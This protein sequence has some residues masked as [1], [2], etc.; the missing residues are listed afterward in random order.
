MAQPQAAPADDLVIPLDTTGVSD[1]TYLN[2]ANVPPAGRFGVRFHNTTS[3]RTF[4]VKMPFVFDTNEF[5]SAFAR[6]RFDR[7]GLTLADIVCG[8]LFPGS[9]ANTNG[10]CVRGST[11]SAVEGTA[12]F[13]IDALDRVEELRVF[14]EALDAADSPPATN[15]DCL[16]APVPAPCLVESLY[17]DAVCAL[18]RQ[19]SAQIDDAHDELDKHLENG[20]RALIQNIMTAEANAKIVQFPDTTN[21]SIARKVLSEKKPL[22]MTDEPGVPDC[23]ADVTAFS[24]GGALDAALYKTAEAST[25]KQFAHDRFELAKQA[26]IAA[27]TEELTETLVMPRIKEIRTVL[28]SE[29]NDASRRRDTGRAEAV[30]MAAKLMSSYS[31]DSPVPFPWTARRV[32]RIGERRGPRRT[33]IT[34]IGD[35]GVSIDECTKSDGV[36]KCTASATIP[37]NQEVRF[38]HATLRHN[39]KS[40]VR[41]KVSFFGRT[42]PPPNSTAY[43]ALSDA[44]EKIPSEF[45]IGL[46]VDGA[47]AY[48]LPKNLD[49]HNRHTSGTGTTSIEFAGGVVDGSV[50]LIFKSGDFGGPDSSRAVN[51]DEYQA[52]VFG[53]KHLTLQYGQFQFARPSSGIAVSETGEGV[54]VAYKKV[55]ASYIIH[56][57]SDE[58]DESISTQDDDYY[59]SMLQMKNINPRIPG[60][61]AVDLIAAYGNNKNDD[62]PKAGDDGTIPL[63]KAAYNFLTFGSEVR[64]SFDALPNGNVVLAGYHSERHVN[65]RRP[66]SEELV[67]GRGT[68]GLLTLGW[69]WCGSKTLFEQS[70]KSRP[71]FGPTFTIGRGTGDNDATDDRDEGY[72][73]ENAG[74]AKDKIFLAQVSKVKPEIGRGLKNKWYAGVQWNDARGSFL[75]WLAAVLGKPE[76]IVS[77][78]TNIALHTYRFTHPIH[79]GRYGGIET[80]IEFLVESPASVT[81]SLGGAYYHRSEAVKLAGVAKDLWQITAGVS[82]KLQGP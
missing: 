17:W 9:T 55:A 48:D 23:G 8:V 32:N 7:G 41:F 43:V 13:D 4:I 47:S 49:G 3:D 20:A 73:G 34:A 38:S 37:P 80:N 53:P 74:F 10:E 5:E 2:P 82:V 1:W 67:K 81:W 78:T 57:E 18:C 79:D 77:A 26:L 6:A 46:G 14:I 40:L 63:R 31:A 33:N 27:A 39:P 60:V 52:K 51:L 76:N 35:S 61:D 28:E 45:A 24:P 21:C 71:S 70:A 62:R 50:A 72:L 29:Y 64:M 25:L 19:P 75:G 44:P 54:L 36:T 16:V 15:E 22:V 66:E 68:V 12:K 11:Q 69:Q 59:V 56:R 42:T 65:P 30:E 58:P